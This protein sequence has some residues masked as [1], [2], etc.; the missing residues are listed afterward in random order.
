MSRDKETAKIIDGMLKLLVVTSMVGGMLL[1]PNA[2]QL[3]SLALKKLDKRSRM[4]NARSLAT[5]MKHS[6]LIDC[7]K[8]VTGDLLITI[9]EQG[10]NRLTQSEFRRLSIPIPDVWDGKWR[11]VL[12]DIAESR[13]ASR[14]AFS[15][16]LR[17]LGFYRLQR[18]VW[19]CPYACDNEIEIVRQVYRIPD[20]D[21]VMV[22]VELIRHEKELKEYF[23][24]DT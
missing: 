21:I 24:I 5:Y 19:V 8:S 3:G 22:E 13:K 12:F 1:A 18:S 17:I 20:H 16:K 14:V 23:K 11:L 7:S 10:R 6:G 9:T 15:R 2:V 4:R